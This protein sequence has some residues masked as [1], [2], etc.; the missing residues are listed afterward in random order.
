MREW[1]WMIPIP[2][3]RV[4]GMSEAGFSITMDCIGLIML[5]MG[6]VTVRVMCVVRAGRR[7]EKGLA[8]LTDAHCHLYHRI[9]V[10]RLEGEELRWNHEARELIG[11]RIRE[12]SRKMEELR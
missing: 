9:W 7:L 2:A 12:L 8:I 11:D 6:A 10:E 5:G 1:E 3:V 4:K